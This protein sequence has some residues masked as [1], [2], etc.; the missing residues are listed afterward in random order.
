MPCFDGWHFQW[1]LRQLS[2][3]GAVYGSG[4]DITDLSSDLRGDSLRPFQGTAEN[5]AD[6]A[7]GSDFMGSSRNAEARRKLAA[8]VPHRI[9]VSPSTSSSTG[10]DDNLALSVKR[11]IQKTRQHERYRY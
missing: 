4:P 5:D 11:K 1:N 10:G 6:G 3:D 9:I 2:P 8:I 7:F